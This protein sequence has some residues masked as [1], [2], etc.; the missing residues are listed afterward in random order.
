M[1]STQ[2]DTVIKNVTS[3]DLS[4]TTIETMPRVILGST[5]SFRKQLLKKLHI[6]FV[7]VAPD[8]DET[9]LKDE[10]PKTMVNR[11]SLK[12]SP[13]DCKNIS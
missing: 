7:Q 2:P 1:H 3:A 9:P 8:I 10:T 13:G 12:K 11:L 5:S 4:Q 6:D